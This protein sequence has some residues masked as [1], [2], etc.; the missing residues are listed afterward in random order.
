[1]IKDVVSFESHLKESP[2]LILF[3]LIGNKQSIYDK[4][5]WVATG[6]LGKIREKSSQGLD[7]SGTSVLNR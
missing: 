7:V 4:G 2:S 3:P 1:V 6:N 5:L